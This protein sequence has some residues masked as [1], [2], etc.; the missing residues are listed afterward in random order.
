MCTRVNAAA[1]L[2]DVLQHFSHLLPGSDVTESSGSVFSASVLYVRDIT[3]ALVNILAF[4]VRCH[5]LLICIS[6]TRLLII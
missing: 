5:T 6:V 1:Q 3:A 4:R 2:M